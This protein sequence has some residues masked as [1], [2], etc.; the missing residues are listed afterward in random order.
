MEARLKTAI[1]VTGTLRRAQ[2]AGCFGA[3]VR[4]GDEDA[5]G[6]ILVMR[7]RAGLVV[8]S[9]TRDQQGGMAWLKATGPDPVDEEKSDAYITRATGRDPDLWVVE[10]ETPDFTACFEGKIL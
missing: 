3:V 1:W 5:G 2:S 6:V 7:G 10:I 4:R 8:L 9:Q